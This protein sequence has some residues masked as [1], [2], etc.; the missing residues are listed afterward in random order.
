MKKVES[1]HS[2]DAKSPGETSKNVSTSNSIN[3]TIPQDSTGVNSYDMRNG[4]ENSQFSFGDGS[5]TDIFGTSA[6]EATH[7]GNET[8]AAEA[9]TFAANADDIAVGHSLETTP[10]T[11]QSRATSPDKGRQG[12]SANSQALGNL[13]NHPTIQPGMSDA[14][15]Y[16]VLSNTTIVPVKD[17]SSQYVSLDL[18]TLENRIKS[19]AEK[20]LY[21]FA[22]EIGILDRNLSTPKLDIEFKF[23]KNGGLKESLSKQLSY[24]GNYADFTRALINIDAL[25]KNAVVIEQH[26][27]KYAGT[28]REDTGL[29]S[30]CVLLSVCETESGLIPVQFE[31]KQRHDNDNRLYLTVALTKIEIGV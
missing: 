8:A 4:G 19:H 31:I 28:S 12:V 6:G 25:L 22:K 18:V 9:E 17:A 1:T 24:G 23:S 15:R 11:R 27:D 10:P 29:K 16:T 13:K 3:T 30:V 5:D 7:I 14:E 20:L 21:P 26:G 2:V